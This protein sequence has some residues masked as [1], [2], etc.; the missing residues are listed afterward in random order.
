MVLNEVL[1]TNSKEE[2]QQNPHEGQYD[3]KMRLPEEEKNI[4][5]SDFSNYNQFFSSA[6][7]TLLWKKLAKK[8]PS[9]SKLHNHPL[10]TRVLLPVFFVISL[11][12]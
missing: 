4:F 6:F 5:H 2:Q 8:F 1:S 10:W 9:L 3:S 7:W 12:Y 11:P